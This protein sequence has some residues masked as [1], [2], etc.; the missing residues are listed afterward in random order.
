MQEGFS[1]FVHNKSLS[2]H[3]VQRPREFPKC[4]VLGTV[5]HPKETGFK[6]R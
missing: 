6:P 2:A 3:S 1:G 5:F 4:L